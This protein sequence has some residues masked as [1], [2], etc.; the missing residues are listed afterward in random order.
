MKDGGGIKLKI[1]LLL[2]GKPD[3][4]HQLIKAILQKC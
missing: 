3:I 2:Q 1:A 4:S